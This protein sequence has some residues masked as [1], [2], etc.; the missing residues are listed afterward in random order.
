MW[1]GPPVFSTQCPTGNCTWPLFE[2]LSWC[3]SCEDLTEEVA[4][5]QISPD[6]E[7]SQVQH[8][9]TRFNLPEW[10]PDVS[11]LP[12]KCMFYL[13]NK[14]LLTSLDVYPYASDYGASGNTTDVLTAT[15]WRFWIPQMAVGSL[16]SPPVTGSSWVPTSEGFEL[17]GL[18]GPPLALAQGVF[19]YNSSQPFNGLRVERFKACAMAPCLR[20]YNV[21]MA[22]GVTKMDVVDTRMG[23][24]TS[25]VTQAS[26]FENSGCWVSNYTLLSNDTLPSSLNNRPSY[27]G[28]SCALGNNYTFCR[29]PDQ[30]QHRIC[31]NAAFGQALTVARVVAGNITDTF[32]YNGTTSQ[33]QNTSNIACASEE[34]VRSHPEALRIFQNALGDKISPAAIAYDRL[35]QKSSGY[36]FHYMMT[37]RGLE[38]TLAD[39]ATAL[40]VMMAN[41]SADQILGEIGTSEA[42]V[43]VRWPWIAFPFVVAFLGL[44]FVLLTVVETKRQRVQI[45]KESGLPLIYHGPESIQKPG[46]TTLMRLS[47]M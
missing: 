15:Q 46:I 6:S 22:A 1:N 19:S 38:S 40:T 39:V 9:S 26:E 27:S 8:C 34:C 14:P 32:L 2:T 47:E 25:N 36:A 29:I 18:W 24:Y 30:H 16:E 35:D 5:T 4:V 31:D 41:A 13:P 44:S 3:S 10:G 7:Y 37:R 28:N 11:L 17:A 12:F 43:R 33:L 23:I 21:S 45:W 42:F 20:R